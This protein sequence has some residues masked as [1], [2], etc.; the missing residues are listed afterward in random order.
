M[1]SSPRKHKFPFPEAP[2]S[3]F[4]QEGHR[5]LANFITLAIPEECIGKTKVTLFLLFFTFNNLC[6]LN[7]VPLERS[8][9]GV[10][11]CILL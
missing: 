11:K 5:N 4:L 7:Y 9:L 3:A 10:P 1:D 6:I 2:T 8:A